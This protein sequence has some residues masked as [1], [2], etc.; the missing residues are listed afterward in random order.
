M[1]R[2]KVAVAISGSGSNLQALIDA[3]TAPDFPAEIVRVVSNRPGVKGLER[4]KAAGIPATLVD[5]KDFPDRESFDAALHE[6]LIEGGAEFVCLAGF[7][8]ILTEDFIT[9]WTDRMI[10]IHPS[11]LPKYKG[12]HTHARAI[13]A[14][15]SHGGATVHMVR[16]DL[17]SGPLLV[18]APVAILPEDSAESLAGRILH[19]EHLIYPLALKLFAEGRVKIT[20]ET[21]IIDG[22]DGPIELPESDDGSDW[23]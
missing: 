9:R 13:E 5:H 14:G 16:V 20:E 23:T 6:A 3:C 1:G 2:L 7:M 18:Q 12:L 19:R 21:A 8:R 11:L 4:A 17:D 22:R 15:D 10:N